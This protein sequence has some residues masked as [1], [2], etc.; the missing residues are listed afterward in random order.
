M[1]RRVAFFL[2]GV[3]IIGGCLRADGQVLPADTVAPKI[4][5][6]PTI[7]LL[8]DPAGGSDQQSRSLE[9]SAPQMLSVAGSETMQRAADLTMTDAAQRMGGLSILR[10]NSGEDSKVIIRGMSPKYNT[11]LVNGMLIPSPDDR[12]RDIPLDLFPVSLA[13]RIEVFKTLTPDMD[14]SGIGGLVN[15]VMK[16]APPA[17]AFAGQLATGYSQLFF[18]RTFS[19]FD[20][21]VVQYKSPYERFGPAYYATGNDFT[22]ANLSFRSVHP[23][24]DALGGLTY[25]R[26]L[27]KEKIGLV[28]GGDY[29]YT[30]R[31]SDGF[32]IDDGAEPGLNNEPGLTDF[33]TRSYSVTNI[34]E[35]LY[36]QWDYKINARNKLTLF[37]FYTHQLDAETRMSV[38][39]SLDEGR[40]GPGTGRIDILERSRLH[41]QQIYNSTLTG[42][43][44]F[45]NQWRLNWAGAYS[46]A[47]GRYPDWAEL[48]GETGRIQSGD[49]IMQTPL[50][51]GPL[52]R[53]WLANTEHQVEGKADLSYTPP[54]F[55]RRLVLEAGTDIH[56]KTRDNFYTDYT[57]N[58]ALTNGTGQPFID[59]YH[60]QW[61][62]N[63]GP[64]DPLGS[65]NNLNTYHAYEQI[66]AE[67][68]AARYR[69]GRLDWVGGLRREST[70]QDVTSNVDPALSYG[71]H[72]RISYADWLPSLQG[73]YVLDGKDQLRFSY[74]KGL[75]RPALSDVTFF[76]LTEEDYNLA[77]NPFII[78]TRAQNADLRFE[79]YSP[80]TGDWQI[81]VFYKYLIEPFEKTLL[82]EGD[83]LYPI[84]ENGLP[85]TPAGVLTEQ[86]K[87]VPNATNYGT[88]LLY[89][90]G[91][92]KWG[93]TANY[94][95]T[96]SR[97]TQTVKW[98][99]RT[100]PQDASSDIV[101]ISRMETRPLEGQ[102][103]NLGNLALW[104]KDPRA[105][106]VQVSLVYTGSR[107]SDVS[108]WYG[109]DQWQKGY[110]LLDMAAERKLGKH[111]SLFG[112]V[113][114]A[115][116]AATIIQV[117]QGNPDTGGSFLPGQTGDGRITVQRMRN[118]AHYLAGVRFSY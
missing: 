75:A 100:D 96:I 79:R 34:R 63:D 74:Y 9:R 80:S 104:Y 11:T 54:A 93:L 87:N 82:N 10:G 26:R 97:L 51:L 61:L 47:S 15:I 91:W 90:R 116:N 25:S 14:G 60:A 86:L 36:N 111:F 107:I 112:R 6:L 1:T 81:G 76:S 52:Q 83:T 71:Q 105:G 16:D 95:L 24:P 68:L 31:G 4:L 89:T 35:S 114:N 22:K 73:R 2:S 56:H 115:L 117:R 49:T 50:V 77:G 103:R 20:R 5:D 108:G 99:T 19:T 17:A 102:S 33:Y 13:Q 118:G 66:G 92:G 113:S 48:D 37:S 110:A 57:F 101:T 69:Q 84:P 65:G 39:T 64:Q 62:N 43:H 58:P 18:D 70:L 21:S 78:R 44:Q 67:F 40:S 85:Y 28:L 38:D 12:N 88:E 30:H 109:L 8:S 55:H 106:T 29:Q 41:I 98:K 3:L 32:F 7:S 23:L 53:Q 59:I 46:Y 72:V 45:G 27:A 42:N 94:T